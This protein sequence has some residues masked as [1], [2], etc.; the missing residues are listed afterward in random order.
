MKGDDNKNFN[1]RPYAR[2]DQRLHFDFQAMLLFQFTPLR[3]G[4]HGALFV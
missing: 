3:E 1:S 2:G 4:R